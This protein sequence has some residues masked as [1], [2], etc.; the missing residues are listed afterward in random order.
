[1]TTLKEVTETASQFGKDVKDSVEDF[2]RSAGKKFE[3]AKEGTGDA[4]HSAASSVRKGSA[5]I[6]NV[7]DRLDA[8]GTFVEDCELKSAFKG[9]RKFGRSHLTESLVVAAA[10]GFL[11]GSA[12]RRSP[13]AGA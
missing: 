1:M 9:L 7:A 13:R 5:A 10:I 4:L 12:F 8:T 11:A 3:A 2:S 6:D